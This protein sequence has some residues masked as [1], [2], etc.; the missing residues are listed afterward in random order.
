MEPKDTNLK[1]K[2]IIMNIA[3]AGKTAVGANARNTPNAVAT[4]LPPLNLRKREKLCPAMT[5]TPAIATNRLDPI[6]IWPIKR[7]LLL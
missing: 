2:S 3:K 4:P 7:A 6:N 5:M 1:I